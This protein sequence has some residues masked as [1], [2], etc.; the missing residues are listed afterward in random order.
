M[1]Y[2]QVLKLEKRTVYRATVIVR[3]LLGGWGGRGEVSDKVAHVVAKGMSL[4]EE[5]QQGNRRK[6]KGPS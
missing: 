6:L 5:E 3:V 2:Q 4:E 1:K